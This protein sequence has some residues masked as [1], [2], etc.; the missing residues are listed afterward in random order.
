MQSK[1][2]GPRG[3]PVLRRLAVLGVLA[4]FGGAALVFGQVRGYSFGYEPQ[5]YLPASAGPGMPTYYYLDWR[6]D[7][8]DPIALRV[9][10]AQGPLLTPR[11]VWI[12]ADGRVRQE[13]G[14]QY[15]GDVS[16]DQP[17]DAPGRPGRWHC[18]PIGLIQGG[19]A[20]HDQVLDERARRRIAPGGDPDADPP[21]PAGHGTG[22]DADPPPPVG[23]GATGPATS[24]D[25]GASVDREAILLAQVAWL[26]QAAEW[27][28]DSLAVWP[29]PWT[30]GRYA[31]APPWISALAQGQ[32]ISLLV[33]TAAWDRPEDLV[34]AR[35]AVRSL[36]ATGLPIVLH[37]AGGIRFFEEFPS[38]PPSE[39]LN[40]CL[41]AWLGLWDFA[42]ATGDA[43]FQ[44]ECLVLL[45]RIEAQVPAYEVTG[46]GLDGWTRYDLWSR[47]PTSPV[48][49]EMHAA[50][51]EAIG[52][53]TGRQFWRSRGLRW[54]AASQP[55]ARRLWVFACVA[56]DKGVRRAG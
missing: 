31:L 10:A 23:Y 28:G 53:E 25:G 26:H 19:L 32:A 4:A 22:P 16:G 3:R 12:S 42:R 20:L 38:D 47:R 18:D 7:W 27:T 33:R 45:D 50:L 56:W 15:D 1:R 9:A 8:S 34:L 21:P 11:A 51:A 17:W 6:R 40:G 5:E 41:F 14:S 54:R 48:Y 44:R 39:V 37:D 29:V 43:E 24:R 52:V 30:A 13:Q 49:Q 35:A 46:L 55:L 36:L 2:W